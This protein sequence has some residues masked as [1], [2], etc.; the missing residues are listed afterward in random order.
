[1][2]QRLANPYAPAQPGPSPIATYNPYI[3]VDY[4]PMPT[5]NK[6][7]YYDDSGK[8][9]K[10]P[11]D[12]TTYNSIGK[13]EPYMA[14]GSQS[15]LQVG[16][17]KNQ[18]GHTFFYH[19]V[20]GN[21]FPAGIS[22]TAPPPTVLVPTSLIGQ[23]YPPFHWLVHLDRNLISPMELLHVS[24]YRPHELTQQ[25]NGQMTQ[26]IGTPPNQQWIG[27]QA[28]WFSNPQRLYRFFDSVQT[29]VRQAGV[30]T[31]IPGKIN[32]NTL[33]EPLPPQGGKVLLALCDPQPGNHFTAND[34][35]TIWTALLSSR[36]PSGTGACRQR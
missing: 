16:Y 2:L 27:H 23:N 15:N 1:M 7:A 29:P 17:A 5:V 11:F 35:S 12:V 19:N 10:V 36:N 33:W 30:T 14:S 20:N 6:A 31:R 4:L 9:V 32:L 28:P 25:F 24:G 21:T 3:T 18:P 8:G 22:I 34:V 13:V 26:Q